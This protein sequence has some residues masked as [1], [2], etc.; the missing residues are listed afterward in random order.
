MVIK[1]TE[2]KF[3]SKYAQ[4]KLFVLVQIIFL[5]YFLNF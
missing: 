4:T 2:Q 1:D 3:I 5:L